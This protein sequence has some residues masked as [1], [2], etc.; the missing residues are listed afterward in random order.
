MY[1]YIHHVQ[2]PPILS[3]SNFQTSCN[4]LK[5]VDIQTSTTKMLPQE[6]CNFSFNRF[7]LTS[8]NEYR[9][10]DSWFGVM[11]M[12]LVTMTKL[13]YT[14]SPVSTEIGYYL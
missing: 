3:K 7:S 6:K 2:P 14:S 8:S 13:S 5:H 10:R 12:A 4:S 11:A 9:K 1:V